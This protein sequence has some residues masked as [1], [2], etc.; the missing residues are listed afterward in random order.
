[1]KKQIE[2]VCRACG[3]SYFKTVHTQQYC[4]SQYTPGSCAWKR[5]NHLKQFRQEQKQK[6][7]CNNQRAVWSKSMIIPHSAFIH[8]EYPMCQCGKKYLPQLGC[9]FCKRKYNKDD[10]YM[11]SI[12]HDKPPSRHW[13][14]VE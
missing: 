12:L 13:V 2:A 1:M 3:C 4:G 11:V 5:R 7:Q 9:L 14:S 10:G 8:Q 6:E